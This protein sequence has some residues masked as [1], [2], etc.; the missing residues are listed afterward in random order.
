[1][2][3]RIYSACGCVDEEGTYATWTDWKDSDP[4]FKGLPKDPET[5]HF[6]PLKDRNGKIIKDVPAGYPGTKDMHIPFIRGFRF[7]DGYGESFCFPCAKAEDQ[8]QINI[9]NSR[10]LYVNMTI[11]HSTEKIDIENIDE[12]NPALVR[13][14][15]DQESEEEILRQQQTEW[16]GMMQESG[17]FQKRKV[18]RMSHVPSKHTN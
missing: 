18:L 4:E 5:G 14:I 8:Y 12:A 7:S 16:V 11:T 3:K 17:D 10:H 13:E 2:N 15:P 1:M 9:C 6:M